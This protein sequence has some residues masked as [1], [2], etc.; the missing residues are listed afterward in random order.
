MIRLVNVKLCL[1]I[2]YLTKSKIKT[3]KEYRIKKEAFLFI[4]IKVKLD[5][6]KVIKVFLKQ[7]NDLLLF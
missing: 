7:F 2:I 5:T 4:E 6:K 1:I 3:Y